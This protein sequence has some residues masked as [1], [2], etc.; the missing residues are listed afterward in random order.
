MKKTGLFALLTAGAVMLSSAGCGTN[1]AAKKASGD[2]A[3]EVG[4]HK[5]TMADASVFIQS[6]MGYYDFD[7]AK[8]TALEGIEDVFER[9]A[10]A[11]KMNIEL[12]DE[13]KDNIIM[14]KASLA[15]R[16]GQTLSEYK[17]YLESAGSSIDFIKDYA[18][19]SVYANKLQ[20]KM[21]GEDE[22][23]T[24]TT[25]EM[26]EVLKSDYYRAKHILITE[27]SEGEDAAADP[28]S[29]VVTE[30]DGKTGE[31][32]ANLV[33]E[34]AKKGENFDEMIKKYNTDPGMAQNPDGYVF[35]DGA[36]VPEFEACV[37]ELQPGEFG[38][39]KTSYGY[40][41]I[42]RLP[43]D[44]TET[45]FV[46]W[47]EDNKSDLVY[48]VLCKKNGIEVKRNQAVIDA[49]TENELVTPEPV[50]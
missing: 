38:I 9:E 24:A 13:D 19:A 10:L 3:I 25:T 32:L 18:T 40:H 27:P 6:Y 23:I 2:V 17:K 41:V 7:T 22:D 31:E 37:K 43:L 36:M 50:Q 45:D 21:A 28:E 20:E 49:Y 33:L 42:Q 5:I 4:D 35:T 11:K 39:A 8:K 14:Q 44:G 1:K 34:K 29:E 26:G 30:E 16:G 15:T 12:T 46:T 47:V 48:K